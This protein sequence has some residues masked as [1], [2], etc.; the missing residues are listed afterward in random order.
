MYDILSMVDANSVWRVGAAGRR[1]DDMWRACAGWGRD[2]TRAGAVLF[3]AGFDVALAHEWSR[4]AALGRALKSPFLDRFDQLRVHR[5]RHRARYPPGLAAP[6]IR[7]G[8]SAEGISRRERFPWGG[9][10]LR[11]AEPAWYTPT[12]VRQTIP[13]L[14]NTLG[15]PA[16][17]RM[18]YGCTTNALRYG[19]F[20]V[21]GDSGRRRYREIFRWGRGTW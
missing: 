11:T 12:H 4:G 14:W 13:P 3:G 18:H 5:A 17:L 19:V 20:D 10:G 9:L 2:L 16:A 21:S 6:T 8:R 15:S 1:P 7:R